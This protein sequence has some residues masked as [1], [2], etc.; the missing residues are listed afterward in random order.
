MKKQF[1]YK[2]YGGAVM[3]GVRKPVI[4]A[5]GS[6][7]ARSFKNAIKQAVQFIQTDLISK[8][9]SELNKK[10]ITSEQA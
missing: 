9:E 10:E 1:D 2:D 3:L 4:K 8:I 6:S 7:D 5:H